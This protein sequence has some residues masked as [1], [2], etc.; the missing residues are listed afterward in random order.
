MRQPHALAHPPAPRAADPDSERGRSPGDREPF[1]DCRKTRCAPFRSPRRNLFR[2]PDTNLASTCPKSSYFLFVG[3]LEPR[4][5]LPALVEA[6]RETHTETGSR[7]YS[8]PAEPARILYPIPRGSPIMGLQDMKQ[9][10]VSNFWERFPTM[11][12]PACFP[13]RSRLFYPSASTKGSGC[14]SSKRCNA[15]AR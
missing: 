14:R 10:K 13:A 6:W 1:P 7:I 2:P 9:R 12:C 11:N 15:D 4:K 3:T 5:N 8:S